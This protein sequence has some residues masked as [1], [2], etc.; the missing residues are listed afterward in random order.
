MGLGPKHLIQLLSIVPVRHLRFCKFLDLPA[1]TH[2]EEAIWAPD[3]PFDEFLKVAMDSHT[4]RTVT[5]R[6][7]SLHSGMKPLGR[8]VR[9]IDEGAKPPALNVARPPEGHPDI[10]HPHYQSLHPWRFLPDPE[11]NLRRDSAIIFNSP[12]SNVIT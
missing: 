11:F 1:E 3:P 6:R 2:I 7:E 4:F 12:G 8:L 5:F 10:W 9:Y